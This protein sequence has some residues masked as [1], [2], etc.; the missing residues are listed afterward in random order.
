MA[1]NII[2]KN[3][4]DLLILVQSMAG[5]LRGHETSLGVKQNTEEKMTAVVETLRAAEMAF[6]QSRKD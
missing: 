1:L 2:P 4:D 3:Q 6:G 5:G